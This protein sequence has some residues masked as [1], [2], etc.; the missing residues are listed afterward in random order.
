MMGRMIRISLTEEEGIVKL[1]R[2]ESHAPVAG[3]AVRLCRLG[4]VAL[5]GVCLGMGGFVG[6]F[7]SH[8]KNEASEK[9]NLQD[10][11]EKTVN[12]QIGVHY[13]LLKVSLEED[14]DDQ[15]SS[16][17]IRFL[18]KER[19]LQHPLIIDCLCELQT[20]ASAARL[21]HD[22]DSSQWKAL[23]TSQFWETIHQL[24]SSR[25]MLEK[26]LHWNCEQ[27]DSLFELF[28]DLP[29]CPEY[30]FLSHRSDNEMTTL[31]LDGEL[32]IYIAHCKTK[33]VWFDTGCFP[34]LWADHSNSITASEHQKLLRHRSLL[35]KSASSFRAYYATD[36]L[37][38]CQD[39][40]YPSSSSFP[41][42]ILPTLGLLSLCHLLEH[43][44]TSLSL[45][46]NSSS[47]LGSKINFSLLSDKIQTLN[48]QKKNRLQCLFDD[49]FTAHL[50]KP[51]SF[52]SFL[53]FVSS[54]TP[55]SLVPLHPLSKSE[56]YD[57]DTIESLSS[58]LYSNKYLPAIFTKE[59]F[60]CLDP[61]TGRLIPGLT[62]PHPQH[63]LAKSPSFL[64]PLPSFDVP[65][66]SYGW[67]YFKLPEIWLLNL[68]WREDELRIQGGCGDILLH[69]HHK[70]LVSCRERVI[71]MNALKSN[72]ETFSSLPLEAFISLSSSASADALP[73]P[74]LCSAIPCLICRRV[75]NSSSSFINQLTLAEWICSSCRWVND[76]NLSQC[77]RC[78]KLEKRVVTLEVGSDEDREFILGDR[79][80][81]QDR[82]NQLSS[83]GVIAHVY[84][85]GDMFDVLF[86]DKV[87][88]YVDKEN[89]V[90][91]G[92]GRHRGVGGEGGRGG[93][94]Q[95]QPH[96]AYRPCSVCSHLNTLTNKSCELCSLPLSKLS[97]NKSECS[98]PVDSRVIIQMSAP[99]PPSELSSVSAA[100]SELAECS[101]L[102][103]GIV[104]EIHRYGLYTIQLIETGKIVRSIPEEMICAAPT[105]PT[106]LVQTAHRRRFQYVENASL[107]LGAKVEARYRGGEVYYP[108]VVKG[109]S[110]DGLY[111]VEYDH[112]E[113]ESDI[114]EEAIVV[115][116]IFCGSF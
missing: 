94:R 71:M 49:V 93:G 13:R 54:Q 91:E 59:T 107:M 116:G 82:N 67:T 57:D 100:E 29:E 53:P 36:G 25:P 112:G 50:D 115:I 7:L 28:D 74:S 86:I 42:V 1:R 77:V 20:I 87:E 31:G 41:E 5:C 12:L 30:T 15:N 19:F 60:Y 37:L 14:R 38:Q 72:F 66:L 32:L 103:I 3:A 113:V 55:L 58:Q 47:L 98:Y 62:L 109:I 90:H 104:K 84:Q 101:N 4:E 44:L 95:Q 48:T 21:V 11:S 80:H 39:R 63:H 83:I 78:H 110:A 108:G 43:Q 33:Y 34:H 27:D 51:F 75:L 18:N 10:F 85:S 65:L 8:D 111:E 35:A 52:G 46:H 99:E 70:C 40:H 79:V 73:S 102:Q 105:D 22:S 56:E 6:K 24:N 88:K 64:T 17:P 61:V 89:L 92:R 68:R 2:G 76:G 106:A 45:N 26:L 114:K 9:R 81:I 16:Q 69:V 97:H 23:P 96:P